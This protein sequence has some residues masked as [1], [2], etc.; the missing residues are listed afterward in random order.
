VTIAG[1]LLAAGGARRFGSQKLVAPLGGVPLVRQAAAPLIAV[2]DA[3]FVVVGHEA[4]AVRDALTGLPVAFVIN[5][6]WSE[7]LSTSLRAGVAVLPADVDAVVIALGDQP[8]LAAGAFDAVIH[9]WR[10]TQRPIV[11]TR[12]DG[13]RGHPVL[14][15]RE[16]FGELAALEGDAGAR[17]L[18]ERSAERV[19]YVDVSSPMPL[20]VDTSADLARLRGGIDGAR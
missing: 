13:T 2:M 11:V 9:E 7:G 18:V 5:H 20:D 19:A 16:M 4:A 17:H 6:A 14:F 1:L 12:Y 8:A 15:A 10:A 3:T